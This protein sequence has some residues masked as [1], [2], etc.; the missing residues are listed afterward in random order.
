VNKIRVILCGQT[1]L[2]IGQ[3]F[4]PNDLVDPATLANPVEIVMHLFDRCGILGVSN[5]DAPDMCR[6]QQAP[7]D[8]HR[9]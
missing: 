1:T 9:A 5:D 8:K 6:G 4:D 7:P 2:T 3:L